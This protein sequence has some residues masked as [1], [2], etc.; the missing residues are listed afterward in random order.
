MVVSPL[1]KSRSN[2]RLSLNILIEYELEYIKAIYLNIR[3]NCRNYTH[4][5]EFVASYLYYSKL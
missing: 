4:W 5:F 3:L 2:I 1:L